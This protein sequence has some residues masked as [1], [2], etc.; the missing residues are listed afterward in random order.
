METEKAFYD[1]LESKGVSRRDFMKYCT[2]LT[3]A[4]GLSSSFVPKV[5]EVF[6]APAQRPPVIWLHFGECTGCSEAVLRTQ[7]PYI[8][9]LILEILS[10]EYHE[11]VMAAAGQQAED[12]LH[13]ALKKYAGKFI[14]VV[15]GAIATKFDGGYGKIGGRTELSMPEP[16]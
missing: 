6:A 4:M 10:L 5:A 9:D 14:C 8:D 7:Y 2:F 3:A 16:L 12:Q 11:T 1:R 15:E 13:M